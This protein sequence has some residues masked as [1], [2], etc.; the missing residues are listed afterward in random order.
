MQWSRKANTVAKLPCNGPQMVPKKHRSRRVPRPLFGEEQ[1]PCRRS[2]APQ[3]VADQIFEPFAEV[4]S[5]AASCADGDKS[6]MVGLS[7]RAK[8]NFKDNSD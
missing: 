6:Q 8:S 7:A 1:S 4:R 5:N 3:F 2:A